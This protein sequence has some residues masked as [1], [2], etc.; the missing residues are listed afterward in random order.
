MH[1]VIPEFYGHVEKNNG[2][3]FLIINQI[4]N[5][6]DVL[7]DHKEV[8]DQILKIINKINHSAYVFKEDYHKFKLS[9]VKCS[10]DEGDFN[11][12]PVG[13]FLK[14]SFVVVSSRLVIEK[15]I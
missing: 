4:G 14:F 6:L 1:L 13:K 15:D 5:N 2:Q 11:E 12:M 10:D 3:K 8:W 7:K 9:S